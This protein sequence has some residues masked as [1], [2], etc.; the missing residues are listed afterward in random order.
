MPSDPST[1]PSVDKRLDSFPPSAFFPVPE[2][3]PGRDTPE[4]SPPS[5][6]EYNQHGVQQSR[7]TVLSESDEEASER[8]MINEHKRKGHRDQEMEDDGT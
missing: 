3:I 6:S 4:D 8:K 1:E 7:P 5:S 2:R